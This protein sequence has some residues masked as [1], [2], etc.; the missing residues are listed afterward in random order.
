MWSQRRPAPPHPAPH[1]PRRAG[2]TSG[3]CSTTA[4]CRCERYNMPDTLKAQ[5]TAFLTQGRVLYSDMGRVLCSIIADTCGWHDTVCGPPATPPAPVAKYGD[6]PLPG[7]AQR[8][9][10]ATPTTTSW[11][12]WASGAWASADL[13]RQ[14]ELLLQGHAPT[15]T[16][17]C[18]SSPAHSRAGQLRRPA[19][20]DERA[21]RAATLPPPAGPGAGRMRP[22]RSSW[23]S[24]APTRPGARRSLPDLAPRERARASQNTER[25]FL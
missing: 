2:P 23:R 12:S 13:V 7:A 1:R 21:G 17:G 4:T 24:G 6:G 11:S 19:R 22:R 25:Y 20:R 15:T 16:A 14:R 8:S 10:T 18:A 3:C 5:H 9:T